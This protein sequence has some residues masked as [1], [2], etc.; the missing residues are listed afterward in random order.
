V[1]RLDARGMER[2]NLWNAPVLIA[3]V[4]VL[5][6]ATYINVRWRRAPAAFRAIQMVAAAAF[7]AGVLTGIWVFYLYDGP[8]SPIPSVPSISPG[9]GHNPEVAANRKKIRAGLCSDIKDKRALLG[10]DNTNQWLESLAKVYKAMGFD[11]PAYSDERLKTIPE[12]K[13]DDIM[14]GQ[15]TIKLVNGEWNCN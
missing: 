10:D 14:L 13:W 5:I 4:L 7:V 9:D 11:L 15:E 1:R 6:S 12:S 8:R 2:L 3:A